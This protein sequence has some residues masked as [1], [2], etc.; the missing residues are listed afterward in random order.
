LTV[1]LPSLPEAVDPDEADG[2]LFELFKVLLAVPT[3]SKA[4]TGESSQQSG[5]PEWLQ[6]FQQA[7]GIKAEE[8]KFDNTELSKAFADL[9]TCA[10]FIDKYLVINCSQLDIIHEATSAKEDGRATPNLAVDL[11][12]QPA[13]LRALL[14]THGNLA[15][16]QTKMVQQAD[17]TYVEATAAD[18]GPKK[19]RNAL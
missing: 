6:H 3:G 2:A 19:A 12:V 5:P 16:Y 8:S 11:R 4:P 1:P 15:P 18:P 17:G 14:D 9:K 7:T 13:M 10:L